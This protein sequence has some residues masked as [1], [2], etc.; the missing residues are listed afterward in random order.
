MLQTP[1]G[2][3]WFGAFGLLAAYDGTSYHYFTF[4]PNDSTSITFGD[5]V[6]LQHDPRGFIWAGS[7]LG[8][9][10][11]LDLRT[12]KCTN[13][14]STPSDEKTIAGDGV[15]GLCIDR[16]GNVWVATN[17]F[18]LSRIDPARTITRYHPPLPASA[19]SYAAA[20]WLNEITEDA[21][22]DGA[23]WVNSKYGLYRFISESASFEL[24]RPLVNGVETDMEFLDIAQDE[25]GRLWLSTLAKGLWCYDPTQDTW[26]VIKTVEGTAEN[27]MTNDLR[28]IICTRENRIMATTHMEGIWIV[29]AN[30]DSLEVY[31]APDE[32]Q[33][34]QIV[35]SVTL[36]EDDQGDI[37]TG[38]RKLIRLTERKPPFRYFSFRPYLS[39][40]VKGNWQREFIHDPITDNFFIGTSTG[41]G[42]L[43]ANIITGEV[44][45]HRYKA[46]EAESVYD[47]LMEA[48]V[49]AGDSGVWIGSAEGLLYYS[50]KTQDIEKVQI[51]DSKLSSVMDDLIRSI[52]IDEQN[53]LWL[54]AERSGLV[55]WN[56]RNGKWHQYLEPIPQNSGALREVRKSRGMMW[57]LFD[58]DV[59]ILDP[60]SGHMS[61]LPHRKGSGHG[62]S[63]DVLREIEIDAAGDAWISTTGGGINRVSRTA[64]GFA[65]HYYTTST[66][67]PSAF[68]YELDIAQDGRVWAGTREGLAVIDPKT[69]VI[70]TYRATDGLGFNSRGGALFQLPSGEILSGGRSGFH[71]AHVDSL[72]AISV[73][74][75]PYLY[76]VETVDDT[77]LLSFLEKAE[78]RIGP[79]DNF[80]TITWG[81]VSFEETPKTRFA[82][83]L[84]GFDDEWIIAG[85][86]TFARYTKLPGGNYTFKL[87]A[88]NDRGE[89]SGEL[90]ML[91]VLVKPPFVKT[92]WFYL[93]VGVVILALLFAI[94]TVRVRRIKRESQLKAEFERELAQV[95][96]H[97]LRAQMNPHFL[98]NSLNSINR[99]IVKN[100]S[101]AASKYLTRFSRLIR[102]ILDNSKSTKVT[103]ANELEAIRLYVELESLRFD[104]KFAF[105]LNVDENVEP[106]NIEIDSMILQPYIENA[107]WHGLMHK[108][109]HGQLKL[110]ISRNHATLTCVVE[111]DGVGRS[112]AAELKSKSAVKD[113]S[114]GMKITSDR[115]RMLNM[116]SQ[117]NASVE[118]T[119]LAQGTRVRIT[120]PC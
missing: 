57:L 5:L 14:Y 20:G 39:G 37:W 16:T 100:D 42:L 46:T 19:K 50:R 35:G 70:V 65:F 18:A 74:P 26:K 33:H 69:G 1:D 118:V 8:G 30:T 79:A 67:L 78:L 36:L 51:A 114:Y 64:N 44:I 81:A 45:P 113:K 92:I 28:D 82:Y 24:F 115:L 23:F 47:V 72:T 110:N 66:G 106:E 116:E 86:R 4:D 104:D 111:D 90:A 75:R 112:K 94:Y 13:Y 59:A 83:M 98:F 63:V 53:D 17:N 109:G 77:R 76:Q 68:V 95:E 27:R 29:D 80:F 12:G 25:S 32:E 41:D 61:F 58:H 49:L 21:R 60:V 120:L 91:S 38:R 97:A 31:V 99:F 89:W 88:M 56:P 52:I 87:K 34:N 84:E 103:L 2:F 11:A 48:I 101:K 6:Q 117:A 15:G 7:N 105:E 55:Q 73:V 54:A 22:H 9:V 71:F 85:D 62:L 10:S 108:D 93:L 119:D 96:M 43:E 102:L 40:N 107:I 3:H